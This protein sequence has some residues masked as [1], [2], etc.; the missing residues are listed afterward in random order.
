MVVFHRFLHT[1][2]RLF[3]VAKSPIEEYERLVSLGK[4]KN[5]P[6][7][8]NIISNLGSLHEQ[9]QKYTPP[10]PNKISHT[11]NNSGLSGLFGSLFGNTQKNKGQ[12][13][14]SDEEY[15]GIPKG[16]Y[17]YGDVGC[18]K[19]MLMDLF[20]S[21]IPTHL[22][23]K[24]LHFHQFMQNL[25][26][27]SHQLIMKHGQDFNT[28]PTLA[29]E[30][31]QESTVLCFDEFQVT[32]VADAMLLRRLLT[33]ALSPSHGLVLF[34]TS[35]RAPDELYMNGIQRES[36]IPCIKLL[37]QRTEVVFLDS[38][39]DYRKVPK[40]ISSIYFSPNPGISFKSIHSIKSANEHI[41]SWYKFLSQNHEAEIDL[42]LKIWGRSLNV[43]KSSPPY[44]AQFS[45]DE[46]CGSPLSAADYLSLAS[47]YNAI[48]VTDI[49]YLSIQNRDKIRRFITF[50]DA[51]YDNHGRLCVTAVAPFN[52]LFVEPEDL[53]NDYELKPSSLESEEKLDRK[54]E[55][56]KDD[57]LIKTH[58]FDKQ[59]VKNSKMFQ[60]DEE[61]F[62]FARA[63]SR[64]S[65]MSTQDWVDNNH[66]KSS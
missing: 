48:I 38:P 61:R 41:E 35:N 10:D 34:A 8:K 22:T 3:Q 53:K 33:A 59:I 56:L 16:I 9:L 15:Q 42:K 28:V 55:E 27:R 45:F 21:T 24:R 58:G 18:G 19:T 1:S 30:I 26:K 17:L 32:D 13:L 25:H 40:P 36:F 65:Q 57:E 64:L 20:Y 2:K 4:L 12:I 37:D 51:I 29:K 62:A 39:T 31:A 7:Q 6:Y 54:E 60:L 63:L 23:K 47:A 49:P 46:L 43:P 14:Y 5:D 50:L 11:S 44:V 66:Y 52:D